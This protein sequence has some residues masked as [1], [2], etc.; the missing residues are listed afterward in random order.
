MGQKT[1]KFK[2]EKETSSIPPASN[3]GGTSSERAL[4][5][6][7]NQVHA[8]PA[9]SEE[10]YGY[11]MTNTGKSRSE[12]RSLFNKFAR[13]ST[14]GE[15]NYQQFCDFYLSISPDPPQ[16]LKDNSQF[17]FDTFDQDQN[18]R[19]SFKYFKLISISQV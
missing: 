16:Y 7:G 11:L 14:D 6:T 15:L 9:L 4:V 1:G 18:G 2:S 5:P 13:K 3:G 17:I 8:I 10:D 12:I 19:V